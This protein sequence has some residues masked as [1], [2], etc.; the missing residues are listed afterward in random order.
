MTREELKCAKDDILARTRE[1]EVSI[2]EELIVR[3]VLLAAEIIV[4][5]I[6]EVKP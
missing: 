6:E 3:A 2:G 5:A 1:H 4:L